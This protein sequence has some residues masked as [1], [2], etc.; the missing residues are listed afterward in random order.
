MFNY[1]IFFF[2]FWGDENGFVKVLSVENSKNSDIV[3]MCC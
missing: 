1:L 2:I 3:L